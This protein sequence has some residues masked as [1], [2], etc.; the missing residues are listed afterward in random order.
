MPPSH[1]A[2][3]SQ[4]SRPR[5][6]VADGR[7][8]SNRLA[9]AVPAASPSAARHAGRQP[10]AARSRLV[11]RRRRARRRPA[12]RAV[13]CAQSIARDPARSSSSWSAVQTASDADR[14]RRRDS[15]AIREHEPA[16]RI[17]RSPAVV[18]HVGPRGVPR[19]DH[20]LPERAEQVVEERDFEAGTRRMVAASAAKTS[21]MRRTRIAAAAR[22]RPRCSA[23]PP[24]V[25]RARARSAV[26]RVAL[27]GEVVGDPRERIDRRDVRPRLRAAAA[28]R[29]RESS[30]SA[31]ARAAR[32]ASYAACG[33]TT[34]ARR[35]R[36]GGSP[37][38]P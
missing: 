13:P 7:P 4:R 11:A 27:V 9:R 6:A 15:P 29:R 10:P 20:V 14:A 16:D 36:R 34:R 37:R 35:R 2:R 30:R 3:S 19:D 24:V 22:R 25:E 32:H 5:D 18:E 23:P 33:V 38:G 28:A 8:A 17:G 1:V 21:P 12:R 31:G 26:E